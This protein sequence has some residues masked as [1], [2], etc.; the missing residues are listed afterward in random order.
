[1][2]LPAPKEI[3]KIGEIYMAILKPIK[4]GLLIFAFLSF[5]VSCGSSEQTDTEK[6]S[7]FSED[8]LLLSSYSTGVENF[9]LNLTDKALENAESVLVDWTPGSTRSRLDCAT[10]PQSNSERARGASR[11]RTKAQ[12]GSPLGTSPSFG[13]AHFP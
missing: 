11:R 8:Q 9:R 12:A 5:L 2:Y 6:N 7:D 1:M 4:Y 10:T 3:Q 13:V